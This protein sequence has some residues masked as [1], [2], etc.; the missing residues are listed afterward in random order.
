MTYEW[1][2]KL[3]LVILYMN[4]SIYI[5]PKPIIIFEEAVDLYYILELIRI[6]F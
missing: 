6:T 5:L 3:I 1:S 4:D 2:I